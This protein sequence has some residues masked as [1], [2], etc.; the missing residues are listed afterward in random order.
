MPKPNTSHM[1][2]GFTQR[3]FE[4]MNALL[5]CGDCGEV[6]EKFSIGPLA[7][8]ALWREATKKMKQ[9][10]RLLALLAWQRYRTMTRPVTSVFD[11]GRTNGHIIDT[12]AEGVAA[13][14]RVH[15]QAA[16]DVDG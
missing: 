10:N 6:A 1:P 3:Q 4:A 13:L 8:Q 12:A 14:S 11:L 16:A 2:F 7:V 15:Q 5:E 9:R